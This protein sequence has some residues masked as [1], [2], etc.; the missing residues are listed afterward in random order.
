MTFGKRLFDILFAITLGILLLP[1]IALLAFVILVRDGRPVFYLSERM[2]TPDRAFRLIKFRTMTENANDQGVSGGDKSDR[3]STTGAMLR[4]TRLDEL[5]Q[6]WNILKGDM[7]FVGPRP[8]LRLYVEEFPQTY[9]RV[10]RNRPGVTGLASL[11]FHEHEARLLAT[12]QT[13]EETDRVY[14][15]RCIP[16]KAR[17]DMIYQR[18]QNICFD[19]LILIKTLANVLQKRGK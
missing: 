4:R 3:I 19:L 12:C 17:L 10:L 18:H 11:H 6:L 13:A 15:R 8:P 9:T 14:R 1:V 7:S 5:P 16:R 2:Q